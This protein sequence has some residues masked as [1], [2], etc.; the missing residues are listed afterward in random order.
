MWCLLA[1]AAFLYLPLAMSAGVA[2]V[3]TSCDELMQSINA[4]RVKDLAL[5]EKLRSLELALRQL[6]NGQGLGF[7]VLDGTVLDKRRL[8]LLFSSVMGVFATLVPIVLSL[9]P[10]A[11]EDVLY[12]QLPGSTKVFG[13]NGQARTYE[14]GAEFCHKIWMLP[15]SI[16]SHA[17]WEAALRLLALSNTR[18][19]EIFLGADFILDGAHTPDGLPWTT[20]K[21]MSVWGDG[22]SPETFPGAEVTG[23]FR[24][25][26]GSDFNYVCVSHC[27][28]RH[29][30]V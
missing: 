3:S 21:Q 6:S 12:G 23:R 9:S 22:G 16:N 25:L 2:E 1:S 8:R 13:F 15:A 27:E 18:P 26:D 29:H 5:S 19:Q 20:A 10:S 4:C 14:E 17:E 24:W 7:T 30:P 28:P 11:S